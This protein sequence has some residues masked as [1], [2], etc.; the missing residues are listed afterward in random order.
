MDTFD[1]LD[2]VIP[3][4]R[5]V[6]KGIRPD[7]LDDPTPCTE[8]TVRDV[9]GHFLGNLEAVAGGLRG[10]PMPASLDPKPEIIGDDPTAAFDRVTSDL[11]GAA[12]S[13]G[14]S[15]RVLTVP[16]GD[17]PAPVL[18]QFVAFDLIMHSWDLAMATGQDYEA[19]ADAL[20]AADAFARQ[21][22][23]PEWRD[24]TTFADEA[25]PPADATPL[26]RL[27]AFSGRRWPR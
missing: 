27:V 14:A 21:T 15:D 1:Q 19:P 10:A 23:A 4:L 2:A 7:Q 8:F 5:D 20:A 26:E 22:V 13:P 6:V 25:E 24:G 11:L 17:V 18:L 12:R 16:F 3:P 9:L